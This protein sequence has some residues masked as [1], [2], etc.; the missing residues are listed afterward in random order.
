[1]EKR[2]GEIDSDLRIKIN[3]LTLDVTVPLDVK[4]A[5]DAFL[6]VQQESQQKVATAKADAAGTLANAQGQA[7]VIEGGGRTAAN[8][9]LTSVQA[10][11]KAFDEQRPYY[12]DNPGLFEK[13]L[14]A[15]TMQRVLTNA[16]DVFYLSGRQP[17]IWLN[18]TPER[19]KLEEGQ[20]P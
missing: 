18:R 19:R 9:L 10:E 15:E 3:S 12:E 4:T 16:V 14:V 1:M 6:K 2:I 13:R 17:R 20:V 5:F 11:A 7:K 8:V